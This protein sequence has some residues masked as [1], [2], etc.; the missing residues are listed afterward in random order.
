[1]SDDYLW[2]R[3]ATPDPEIE[4]LEALLR[5]VAYAHAPLR[6]DVIPSTTTRIRV[7]R[8]AM[9]AAG[10]VVA[11]GG[12]YATHRRAATPWSVAAVQGAPVIRSA[13]GALARGI[14]APGGVV[15]TDARSSAAIVIG[16][17]GRAE[18]GPGSRLR[19]LG[20]SA[21]EYRL[22]LERGTMRAS[23]DAPPRYF[24]VQTASALA[25]DLGCV[26]TLTADERGNG[27]LSVE[28]GEVELQHG[29]VRVAVLAGNSAALRNGSGPGLP[30]PVRASVALRRAIDTYDADPASAGALDA[31]LAAADARS[32]ITLWHLL[33]RERPAARDRVYARLAV[34]SPPPAVVTR[35]RII[36]GESGALQRWRT[37]LQPA[38]AVEPP[39]W[40]RA[41]LVVTR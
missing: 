4:R 2:D 41:W 33:Q 17:I 28:E 36:R 34:I 14:V 13:D 11:T 3:S 38:W 25:V 6:S 20:I 22:S 26:Y 30:F 40:R 31:V 9:L 32:T 1:M 5:P 10:I 15:E 37:D 12:W 24:L 21:S 35:E 18:L 16:R 39:L 19:L 29:D 7:T 8:W 23:I 27:V